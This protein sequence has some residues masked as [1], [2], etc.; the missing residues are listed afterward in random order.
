MG[1]PK[2][3]AAFLAGCA[4]PFAIVGSLFFIDMIKSLNSAC[5]KC[6]PGVDSFRQAHLPGFFND[7]VKE[8]NEMWHVAGKT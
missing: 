8:I 1:T 2:T 3:V 6:L 5:K 7:T 4:V